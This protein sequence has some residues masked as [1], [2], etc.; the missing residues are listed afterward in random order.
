MHTHLGGNKS[1]LS[2]HILSVVYESL[3]ESG[4]YSG[5]RYLYMHLC[6][7]KYETIYRDG[8][9]LPTCPKKQ[10]GKTHARKWIKH[11]AFLKQE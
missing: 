3:L 9:W 1:L 2:L 8:L 11:I 10:A 5:F 4:M 6:V 7:R